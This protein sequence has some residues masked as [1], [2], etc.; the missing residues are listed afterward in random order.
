MNALDCPAGCGVLTVFLSRRGRRARPYT[1]CRECGWADW[2]GANIIMDIWAGAAA[3]AQTPERSPVGPPTGG[4]SPDFA[5]RDLPDVI[6]QVLGSDPY[7]E[8]G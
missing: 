6:D 5:V 2:G 8:R 7:E 3:L 1:A 4:L